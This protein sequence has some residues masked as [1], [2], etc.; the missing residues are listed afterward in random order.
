MWTER[1]DRYGRYGG[2][3]PADEFLALGN[4]VADPEYVDRASAD[5]RV[6]LGSRC[7]GA[8]TSSF[9]IPGP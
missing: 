5:Y 4:T 9:V 1:D 3:Q 8:Y 2:I 6:R 7:L